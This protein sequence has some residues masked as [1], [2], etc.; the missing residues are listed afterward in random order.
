VAD[1][2]LRRPGVDV[3][4]SFFAA[5][6]MHNKIRF[7]FGELPAESIPSLKASL[8]DHIVR[9]A[10][11]A[12]ASPAVL[13]RLC[14]ALA[15]LAVQACWS[16]AVGELSSTLLS[17]AG[18]GRG[19]RAVL[20][21]MKVLPEECNSSRI[22]VRDAT[23]DAFNQ[24]LCNSVPTLFRILEQLWA[25]PQ[26]VELH[27]VRIFQCLQSWIR[28]TDVPPESVASLPL[29]SAAFD[30]LKKDELFES[31]ID[32]LVEVLRTYDEPS[33]SMPIVHILVPRAMA[34]RDAY[35]QCVSEEDEDA[36]R[37]YCRLLTEMGE[38]YM[39][40]VMGQE[41]V[42]Q[43]V[44]V[45]MLLMC[46]THPEPDVAAIPLHFWYRLSRALERLEPKELQQAKLNAF[47]PYLSRL[48]DVLGQLLRYPADF[49]QLRKD[50]ADDVRKHRH[51]VAD[52]LNDCC[53][54]LGG[55]HCLMRLTSSLE[56]EVQNLLLLAPDAQVSRW[57]GAEACLYGIKSIA[58]AIP[59]EEGSSVRR[60]MNVIM[61]LPKGLL[62]LRVTASGLVGAYSHWLHLNPSTVEPCFRYLL[63]AFAVPKCSSVAASSIR[64]ICESCGQ[65][66]GEPVLSLHSQLQVYKEQGGLNLKDELD[67]LQGLC[68]I[69]ST[70]PVEKVESA[71]PQLVGP[72]GLAL[73]ELTKSGGGAAAHSGAGDR[74]R[75]LTA[76]LD[77]LVVVLRYVKPKVPAG[78]RHPILWV[79]QQLWQ[80]LGDVVTC[81]PSSDAV[82]EHVCRCYKHA[83]RNVGAP[84]EPLLQ[85]LVE[86]IVGS[87]AVSPHSSFIYCGSICVGEFG[88][89]AT[90]LPLL[91]AM[92]E[93]FS[94]AT[95]KLLQS[96]EQVGTLCPH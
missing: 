28:H 32:L 93:L 40:L 37:G 88:S 51:D 95:F 45:E 13:T 11:A 67:I 89:S 92:V 52:V 21:L 73:N 44:L 82:A 60:V 4:T 85:A 25:D 61:H 12:N 30:S 34:C 18:M 27:K 42:G 3:P 71:L 23:R 91:R 58:K 20:E 43:V 78:R 87:F 53:R 54:V 6:T 94:S 75:A 14:L 47:G 80:A 66:L 24:E 56:M 31:A 86:R 59:S 33:R 72:I 17:G 49:E 2:L 36:A 96:D 68:H 79:M 22:I 90:H 74:A 29:L 9:Y 48:V 35:L 15:A 57:H 8:L 63:E 65:Q 50:Q 62:Q 70:L 1:T 7:D 26:A 5:M 76:E 83:M 69:L 55:P 46:T 77:R 41:D 81:C 84:F 39:D 10:N 38:S 64:L 16:G 19:V